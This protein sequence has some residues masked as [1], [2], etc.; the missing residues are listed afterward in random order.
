MVAELL[1]TPLMSP[2]VDKLRPAGREP[3][4]TD[5]ECVA[6]VAPPTDTSV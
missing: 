3:D 2:P 6:P 5:Q 1:G 4:E